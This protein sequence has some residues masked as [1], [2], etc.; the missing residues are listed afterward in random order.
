[1]EMVKEDKR[2]PVCGSFLNA[3]GACLTC[4]EAERVQQAEIRKKNKK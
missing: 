2:C 1:M 4:K 3:R